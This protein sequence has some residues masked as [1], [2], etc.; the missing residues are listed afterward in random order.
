MKPFPALSRSTGFAP[1]G[2]KKRTG[3]RRLAGRSV[4]GR[5]PTRRQRNSPKRSL[6]S[7]R[8]RPSW[9]P[10]P[11][12]RPTTGRFS[13]SSGERAVDFFHACEHLSEVS[14]RREQPVRK[15]SPALR[16]R[17]KGGRSPRQGD[18]RTGAQGS[19]ARAFPQAQARATRTSRR[20]AHTV[21]QGG[22]NVP[23]LR[24]LVGPSGMVTGAAN[25]NQVLNAA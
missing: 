6:T 24:A 22:Q 21:G 17:R 15:V 20:A 3:A 23:T 9:S 4:L 14:D 10:L 1:A 19:R 5:K 13:T 2:T 11:T 8:C 18:D 25:E 7:A 12:P 16:C